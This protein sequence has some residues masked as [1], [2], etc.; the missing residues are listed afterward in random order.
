VKDFIPSSNISSGTAIRKM[1]RG[2]VMGDGQV[3]LAGIRE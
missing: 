3:M 1:R 2:C